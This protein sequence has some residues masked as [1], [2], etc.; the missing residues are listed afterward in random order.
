MTTTNSHTSTDETTEKWIAKAKN[1]QGF[2]SRAANHTTG[3]GKEIL[4][5][6]V[7]DLQARI[8][9]KIKES[10]IK[11]TC[12]YCGKTATGLEI[13]LINEGWCEIIFT[14]PFKKTF[15]GCPKHSR[16]AAT[17]AFAAIDEAEGLK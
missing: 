15:T 2:L 11:I 5:K 13:E 17:A 14:S 6:S 3:E 7:N 12:D 10:E 8:Q 4:L 16:L 1:M 9:E